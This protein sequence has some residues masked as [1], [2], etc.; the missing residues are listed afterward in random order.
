MSES[1]FGEYKQYI[2]DEVLN[3]IEPKIIN[4]YIAVLKVKY[5]K[6]GTDI[7]GKKEDVIE[8]LENHNKTNK[9]DSYI[10]MLE[11]KSIFLILGLELPDI[12]DISDKNKKQ[13]SRYIGNFVSR[14][15]YHKYN[16]GE[17]FSKINNA[18]FSIMEIKKI[19]D[20]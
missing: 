9:D 14:K 8:L 19:E 17:A 6:E 12:Y 7:S 13:V 18:L 16:W 2:S 1:R 15:L 3:E 11:I 5:P 10:E 20:Q 4:K